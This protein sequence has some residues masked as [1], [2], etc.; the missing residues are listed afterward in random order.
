MNTM[1]VA[2]VGTGV[3]KTLVTAIMCHQ[4]TLA[5]R[6]VHAIK[7]V[8]SG[9]L[10]DDPASDPALI[11][12]SLGREPTFQGIAE[13][14]PWR[15]AAPLSPHLA[16]R[17]EGGGISVDDVA[18]FCRHYEQWN[19]GL[20]LIEGAGGVMTPIDD[21]HTGL[22]LAACLA[23]P[24]ILVTGT[25]LGALS[26]TL[27]ALVSIRARGLTVR[28]IVV[29]ESE[30]DVGLTSTVESLGHF[31]GADVPL[32]ALPRLKGSDMEKWRDAPSL[33]ALCVEEGS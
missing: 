11:L 6:A 21:T 14:S 12:R 4:L 28:G 31:T 15:F 13:I 23:C 24:V 9:F 10:A 3:G 5:G 27:T 2:S 29:S 30:S 19:D 26:H 16:A 22:D 32:V 8:V 1:F 18:A 25:Y 33:V 7:P 17:K 20:L